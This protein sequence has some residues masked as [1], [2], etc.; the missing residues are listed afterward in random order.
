[1][2]NAVSAAGGAEAIRAYAA[3]AR[4]QLGAEQ[5]P[6]ISY[7]GLWLLL[8]SL[9]ANASGAAATEL[10]EILG[11]PADRATQTVKDVLA[12]EHPVVATAL[13]C[14][15]RGEFARG[16]QLPVPPAPMPDQAGLDAWAEQNTRGLIRRFPADA[17]FAELLIASAVVLEPSW[18]RPLPVVDGR[19]ELRTRTQAILDTRAAGRV[20]VAIPDS[21][22]G[23]DVISVIAAPDVAPGSVWSGLDEVVARLLAGDLEHGTLPSGS[24]DLADG[25]AW[26]LRQET[27]REPSWS[28]PED[29]ADVWTSRL[30]R[31]S[32][33][34]DTDLTEAPG[35][36]EV[37]QALRDAA[38]ALAG[39]AKCNQAAHAAYTENGF[40]AAAVTAMAVAGGLPSFVER[41]VR[42]IVVEFDR[43][44]ALVAV[45]RGGAWE[46]V[47][48][49]SCW[50]TPAD[51][52]VPAL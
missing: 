14:W 15:V 36:A 11:L 43:P 31:W 25:H 9:S 24:P 40:S 41:T 45:A 33:D 10:A 4:T 38:P 50:V 52:T 35:V 5:T 13:G 23:I 3:R 46:G 32:A 42:R 39:P 2:D 17:R 44:H 51:A 6:V 21:R 27:V 49:V 19:L 22:D 48:L 16:A 30:P 28:A 26:T 37:V 7:A 47:P 12:Q 20:A 18:V 29:G 8:A 1:M 34:A